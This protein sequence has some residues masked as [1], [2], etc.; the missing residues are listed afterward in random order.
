MSIRLIIIA[1]LVA[2]SVTVFFYVQTFGV[3][4]SHEHSRWGEFGSFIGGVLGALF[5]FFT[6]LYLAFQVE[7]QWKESQASRL[8][9]EMNTRE[10]HIRLCLSLIIVKL[11]EIDPKLE[12]P[13]SELIV[14]IS[15][16]GVDE[17]RIDMLKLGLSARG[18]TLAIWVNIASALSYLKALDNNRYLN[19]LTL[20]AVQLGYE[21]C[22]S[23]D[24][25]VF[26]A[27]GINFEKHFRD[28]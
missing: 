13:L 2:I 18:E 15:K 21:L 19:Q 20:V 26:I 12:F 4:L 7:M 27:T 6:L 17:D 11:K 9:S 22:S 23:L 24:E 14:R 25:V 3:D 16:R 10:N 8:D 5:A 1:A 28:Q